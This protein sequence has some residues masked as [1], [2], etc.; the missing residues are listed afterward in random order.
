MKKATLL[1][2]TVLVV[3][4]FTVSGSFSA[5]SQVSNNGPLNTWTTRVVERQHETGETAYSSY[6]KVVRVEK[7]NGFDRTVFEFTG[8]MPNYNIHYLATPYYVNEDESKERI[9]IA[10]HAFI[11]AGFYFMRADETQLG[12]AEAPGFYPKGKLRMP[13]LRELAD[14]GVWEGGYDFVLGI[15]ARQAF[16][17]TEL[18]NPSQVVIDIKH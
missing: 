16:R 5:I 6:L 1:S 14:R 15:K 18:A 7:H 8:V 4:C 17:V 13:S 10:G 12:L 11:Q 3:F 2:V 9:R